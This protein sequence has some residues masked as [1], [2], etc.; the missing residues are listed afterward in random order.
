MR[1]KVTTRHIN[2]NQDPEKLKSYAV[3]KSKR[4]ERYLKPGADACDVN[5]VLSAEKFRD[6]AEIT[7][8]SKH[9][10]ASGSF[11]TTD[12]YT[13]IDSAVDI[14]IKQLK[15]ETDKK[16]KA[17]RR[18]GAKNKEGAVGARPAA[19]SDIGRFTNIRV[20]RLPA[21][22]MTV[23]EATLQLRVSGAGF[24]TFRNSA[25]DDMNVLYI[26]DKGQMTLIE[27]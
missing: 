7:I 15:K 24:V 1:V 23:E 3:K 5:F 9:L 13:A 17:K 10:K 8:S 19:E 25:S 2:N 16:K 6:T 18:I 4:I 27:P 21:K 20:R 22:P 12:M 11:E 14:I 26:D